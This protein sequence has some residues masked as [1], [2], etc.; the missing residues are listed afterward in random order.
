MAT[1]KKEA[2]SRAA[3]AVG[4]S[5]LLACPFCGESPEITGLQYNGSGGLVITGEKYNC[6]NIRCP[7]FC[8]KFINFKTKEAAIKKWNTRANI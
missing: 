3:D 2:K 6:W 7:N 4:L 1:N 8:A 5:E